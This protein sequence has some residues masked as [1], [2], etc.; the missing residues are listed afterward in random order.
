MVKTATVTTL[1]TIIVALVLP[2]GLSL[3]WHHWSGD[4]MM[5]PLGITQEALQDQGEADGDA[6]AIYAHVNWDPSDPSFP[7]Q[8]ALTRALTNG[9]S[10]KG[11]RVKVKMSS[12]GGGTAVTYEVGPSTIGPF[13]ASNA[14]KGIN[15]ATAA[16][17]MNHPFEP[18]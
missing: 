4:P 10:A 9:F 13:P 5:R 11:L 7:S 17:R 6:L 3:L 15:A 14:A 12:G 2:S 18:K 1:G 16:Y 8:D